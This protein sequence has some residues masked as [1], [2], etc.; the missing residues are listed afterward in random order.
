MV[1]LREGIDSPWVSPPE[2]TFVYMYQFL[3]L[4]ACT[5]LHRILGTHAAPSR[6]VTLPKDAA[7][8]EA[9]HTHSEWLWV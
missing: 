2:F 9:N 5:F 3:L 7:R 4:N 1:P 6:G 8:W